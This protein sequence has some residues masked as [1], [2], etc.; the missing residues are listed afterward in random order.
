M[1][2]F[3]RKNNRRLMLDA[4]TK[5]HILFN[6]YY[7]ILTELAYANLRG[8]P[9]VDHLKDLGNFTLP[10]THELDIIT[11]NANQYHE[12]MKSKL[13]GNRSTSPQ[14]IE[15]YCNEMKKRLTNMLKFKSVSEL[16][17]LIS[18]IEKIIMMLPED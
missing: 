10:V 14:Q 4:I 13:K 3:R 18:E 11:I 5:V 12:K 7:K 6:K 9:K 17:D 16:R 1:G 15:T 2:L 8:I